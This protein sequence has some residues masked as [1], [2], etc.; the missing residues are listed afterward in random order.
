MNGSLLCALTLIRTYFYEM[1][2]YCIKWN[3]E[4]F[5]TVCSNCL[6]IIPYFKW[7]QNVSPCN[8]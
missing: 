6:C 7:N 5:L 2:S 3:V 8:T 1:T 4:W